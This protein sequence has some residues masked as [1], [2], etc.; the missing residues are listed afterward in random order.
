MIDQLYICV[1]F[2]FYV[3]WLIKAKQISKQAAMTGIY[4]RVSL[5]HSQIKE[6]VSIM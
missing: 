3:M 1:L 2:I 5:S 4:N 6:R